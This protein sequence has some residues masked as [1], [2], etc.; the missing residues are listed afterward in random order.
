MQNTVFKEKNRSKREYGG[1]RRKYSC[2]IAA[3][4]DIQDAGCAEGSKISN[5]INLSGA[6]APER[7][8]HTSCSKQSCK[9]QVK[10]LNSGY[11]GFRQ[12]K[13][14]K[15]SSINIHNQLKRVLSEKC[16]IA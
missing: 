12:L 9:K 4:R 1:Q 14:I 7:E 3:F 8:K 10:I 11:H 13:V 15:I 6:E 5:E 2:S 16:G